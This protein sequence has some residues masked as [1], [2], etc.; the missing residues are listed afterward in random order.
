MFKPQNFAGGFKKV[1]KPVFW[2]S[3]FL[4]TINQA[5]LSK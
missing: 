4:I 3:K 5:F 2:G 1:S